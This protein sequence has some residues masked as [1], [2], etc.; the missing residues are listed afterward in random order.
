[1][2]ASISNGKKKDSA[3]YS[4]DR[5]LPYIFLCTIGPSVTAASNLFVVRYLM[6]RYYWVQRGTDTPKLPRPG[7]DR[8]GNRNVQALAGSVMAALATLDGVFSFL[9]SPFVQSLSDRFGRRPLLICLP[10]LATTSTLSILTA[11]LVENTTVA[12]I[13]LTT[14]GIFVSAS[15]KSV[16]LPTLCVADVASE[17]ARTRFY[18]RMEA[19]ALLGPGTAYITSALVSRYIPNVAVPYYIALG[20]Q[21]GAALYAYFFI[22]ETLHAA[23]DTQSDHSGG[24]EAQDSDADAGSGSASEAESDGG[25]QGILAETLA[26][27]VKPLRLLIP[28][29]HEGRLH[30]QLF[31]VSLS[32]LMT[33]AGTVFIAT[34]SLLFLTDK[35]NFAP[36][37]N[38]WMLAFLTFSR[39]AYLIF[40]FPFILKFGR[41]A[42]NRYEIWKQHRKAKNGNGDG[43][44]QPLIT[45]R[46]TSARQGDANHFDVILAFL[47]VLIDAVALGFVSLSLSYQQVLAAF[48]IMAF[49]AGDNPT[50]KAVF[51]SFAPPEHSSQALAALDMVFSA[52][53]LASPPLLGS[54]YAAFVE[55]GRPE[56]LFLT[57]GGLCATGALLILPLMF[58]KRSLKKTE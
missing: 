57:A 36:E 55:I 51:V 10:L 42:L 18:S 26:V 19:V 47:S 33:T 45:R 29:R 49:G 8:C 27:P 5:L 37:N 30:W 54:L 46:D 3:S 13:L 17:D 44:R 7:D 58:T 23:S 43:E 1:M 2:P 25:D 22:P 39:F 11:Y 31:V 40:I 52:A 28:H 48:A 12:W 24:E 4:I 21:V 9:A 35:F 6:C 50:F 53:K 16:F 38:A 15:T 20:A 14:T 56:L 34:A 32:L 41:S